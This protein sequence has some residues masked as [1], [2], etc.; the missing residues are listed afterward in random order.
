MLLLAVPSIWPYGYYQLLRWVVS[1]SGLFNAHNTYKRKQNGWTVIMILVAIVFNPIS[2]LAFEKGV[3]VIV[4]IVVAI[5][6]FVF[7]SK[8]KNGS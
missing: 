1:V 8:N 3:W 7:L 5:I 2:P 6:M 4:D